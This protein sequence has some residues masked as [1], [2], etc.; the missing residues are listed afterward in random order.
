MGLLVLPGV[1]SRAALSTGTLSMLFLPADTTLRQGWGE[2]WSGIGWLHWSMRACSL[3]VVATPFPQMRYSQNSFRGVDVMVLEKWFEEVWNKGNEAAM[4]ELMAADVVIH[5][6]MG[7]DGEKVIQLPE[8]KRMFRSLLADL[9]DVQVTVEHKLTQGD[10]VAARCVITA[11]DRGDGSGRIPIRFTGM[12]MVH[13]REGK[14][15]ESWNYFD[16]ESMYRQ[17][18]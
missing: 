14:I 9:S 4:D 13:V 18:E 8:F 16:F 5:D 3:S 15:V 6:L 11:I 2:R 1:F 10:M 12:I 17:M 7:G